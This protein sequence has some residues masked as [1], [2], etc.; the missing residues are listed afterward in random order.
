MRAAVALSLVLLATAATAQDDARTRLSDAKAQSDAATGRA[1]RLERAAAGEADAARQAKLAEAALNA[2]IQATQ[3]DIAAAEARVQLIGRLIAG[4]RARLAADQGPVARLL[5]A[6]QS[7][8]SRPTLVAVVQPGS[9][10]DLVHVRAVLGSTLPAVRRRTAGVRA[11]L[12][13]TRAL[14]RSAALAAKALRDGR[15]RLEDQRLAFVR[16]E[17]QHRF[18]AG[19]IGRD[20]A[21]ESERAL[22]LGE[23][24]RDLIGALGQAQDAARVEAALTTLPGP[25]PRPDDEPA[26]GKPA[27]VYRLPAA[28]RI[29]TGLGEISDN[30]VRSRGLTLATGAGARV[31]APAAGRVR[32]AGRFR[33]YGRVVVI[34]HGAGWTTALTGLGETDV[35]IGDRVRGGDAVGCA[36]PKGATGDD[37][38]VTVELRRK[39]RPVD[40]TPLIG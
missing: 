5:A 24:A 15:Q 23:Q 30:G 11:E 8:A 12:D 1:A 7:L 20:A 22:A 32:Y 18:R 9:V 25:L 4:Q 35:A 14:Q 38:R 13:R 10:D 31:I 40:M 39:G 34:D 26:G 6:I 3:A 29:V 16:L 33:D 17:A 19:A 27:P 37:P 2:R 36:G 28:G 21:F